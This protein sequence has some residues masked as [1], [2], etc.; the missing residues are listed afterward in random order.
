MKATNTIDRTAL[1]KALDEYKNMALASERQT[2]VINDSIQ[3]IDEINEQITKMLELIDERKVAKLRS[4]ADIDEFLST[5]GAPNARLELLN[6][7]K[8]NAELHLYAEQEQLKVYVDLMISAKRDCWYQLACI[9]FKPIQ[10]QFN[11]VF[12]AAQ[13]SNYDILRFVLAENERSGCEP[14]TSNLIKEWGM[15]E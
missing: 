1:D 10:R 15:P 5:H 14:V 6:A 4:I 11:Q 12:Y 13:S 8:N 9:L 3:H 2:Q 7:A